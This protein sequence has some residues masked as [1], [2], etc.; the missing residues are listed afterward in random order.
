MEATIGNFLVLPLYVDAAISNV[1]Q[2][3]DN[4]Q[5][6]LQMITRKFFTRSSLR[7]VTVAQFFVDV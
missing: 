2:L 1:N 5:F 3:I 4:T 7:I 6:F